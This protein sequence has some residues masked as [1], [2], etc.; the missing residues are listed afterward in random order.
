[1]LILSPFKEVLFGEKKLVIEDSEGN[2]V[3]EGYDLL[4]AA[5]GVHSVVRQKLQEFDHTFE[6]ESFEHS[7]VYIV[8]RDLSRLDDEGTAFYRLC[9]RYLKDHC[10]G[11]H[12]SDTTRISG[13][14]GSNAAQTSRRRKT[15]S[16]VLRSF[17]SALGEE[18]CYRYYCGN[19]ERF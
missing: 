6:V 18:H 15:A 17:L 11:R 9:C 14:R 13:V 8:I 19:T 7:D 2:T 16:V 5:D 1:M 4:I 12:E 3:E 10:R